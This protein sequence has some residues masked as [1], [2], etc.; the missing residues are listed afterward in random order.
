MKSIPFSQ[1]LQVVKPEYAYLRIKPNNAVRNQG[2]HKIA[3]AIAALYKGALSSVKAEEQRVIKAL[4]REFVVGTRYSWTLPAKVSYYIYMEQRKVEFFFIVPR[5]HLAYLRE[6]MSDVWGQV[7]IEEVEEL[8]AI[9]PAAT[10]YELVYEKEDAL[11]LAVDRR[12]ND[13]LNSNLNAVELL[14]EGDRLGVFY[15]FLPGSQLSWRHLYRATIDKVNRRLPVERNKLGTAYALKYLLA[16]GNVIFKEIGEALGSGRKTSGASGGG[17]YMDALLD[18]LN[19]ARRGVSESTSKKAAA[20]VLDTQIVVMAESA[21]GMRQ[22]NAARSLAQSFDTVSEDNRLQYRPYR[23]QLDMTARDIRAS[24]NK[25]GD[26]E[27][28]NF[29]ALAGRDVLERYNFIERVE[30]QETEVPEDLKAGVMCIGTNTY[31]GHAQ[32]AYLSTD[33]EFRNLT[34][35]IIG[36]TRAGKSNL[37]GNLCR[38]AINGGE[39]VI[40][41]DFVGQCELSREVAAAIPMGKTL[42]IECGDPRKLQGMGYNEV[43]RSTDPFEQYDNAKKQTTQLLTLVNS[44]NAEETKLSAKMQRYLVSASLVAFMV[45]G[46]IRSVFDCLQDHETRHKL[47]KAVPLLQRDNLKKYIRSLLELDDKDKAGEVIGTKETYIVGIID[48]LNQLEQNAY[49][50]RMLDKGTAGNVNLVEEM[51]KNQLICI[52]M[53]SDMFGTDSERDVYT[54]YWSTKIWL[55]LQMR[56]KRLGGDRDKMTKVNLIV[57][58]LYQVQHTEQFMRSKLS[59]YAKFGLKPIISAHYLNQIKHIREELRSANASYLLISGCDKKNFLELSS[60][61]LPYTEEDLLKLPR[62]HSLNLI[63]HKDGYARFITHLPGVLK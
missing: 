28:Q 6:K 51:Q 24:R 63:K 35:V 50:E 10:R 26:E 61:L 33:R 27:A 30:T 4:G 46:S 43:G 17:D 47:I 11:S 12:S 48:R 23:R 60:E 18:R 34:T 21:D 52:R 9:G 44:I 13:L 22:R 36:P 29:I 8:P 62:Y 37:I 3:R 20:T 45:G 39:C 14:E 55:A 25:I 5:A 42:V 41:F 58:E 7:T 59:Q 38:D 19:G 1:L 54:T 53:P 15:N 16:A 57:D 49:M 31:R 2:T 32:A 56:S 40:I